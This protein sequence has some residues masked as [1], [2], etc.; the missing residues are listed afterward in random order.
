MT[1]AGFLMWGALSDERTGVSTIVAGP[2]QGA[3]SCL[4]PVGLVTVFHCLRFEISLFVASYDW[5]GY[6]G[7]IRPRL[8]TAVA[9]DWL[10]FRFGPGM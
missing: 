8:H 4:S 3:F 2:R 9:T 7:G 1:V 6:G 10:P 5:Q